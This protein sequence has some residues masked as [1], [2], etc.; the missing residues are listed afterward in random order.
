MSAGLAARVAGNAG[1]I[2]GSEWAISAVPDDFINVCVSF[3]YI[4]PG[5]LCCH[6]IV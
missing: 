1:Y 5:S 3:D 2:P 6:E 4:I